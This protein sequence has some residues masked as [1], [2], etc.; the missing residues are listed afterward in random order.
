MSKIVKIGILKLGC[1]G[2]AP[3][4]EFLLDERAERRDIE[5]RVVGSGAS[6]NPRQCKEAAEV[7]IQYKP[8]FSS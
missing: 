1:V 8:D 6:M 4:L 7:L 3:L 5:V 2:S